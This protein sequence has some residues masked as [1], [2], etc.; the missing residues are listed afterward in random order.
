MVM[1]VL[2]R[3]VVVQY[4]RVALQH[5]VPPLPLALVLPEKPPFLAAATGGRGIHG[6]RRCYLMGCGKS[7]GGRKE[8]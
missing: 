5:K 2:G 8:G 4:V 7:G 6:S 1:V 3:A